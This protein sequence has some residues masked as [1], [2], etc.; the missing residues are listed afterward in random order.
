[1]E[2]SQSNAQALIKNAIAQLEALSARIQPGACFDLQVQ[3][4]SF[5]QFEAYLKA[6]DEIVTDTRIGL[7]D[8]VRGWGSQSPMTRVDRKI[9]R[10]KTADDRDD[11]LIEAS[12]W[13]EVGRHGEAA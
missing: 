13:A 4:E 11:L 2:M 9:I 8:E 10:E 12:D 5:F 1:M 6:F 7:I 3:A